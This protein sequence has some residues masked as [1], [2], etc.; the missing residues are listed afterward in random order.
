VQFSI[1]IS[2]HI[3]IFKLL[4]SRWKDR[5]CSVWVFKCI[6]IF[7]STVPRIC[8]ARVSS[9]KLIQIL[10][11]YFP[12]SRLYGNFQEKLS[13]CVPHFLGRPISVCLIECMTTFW[14]SVFIRSSVL[15]Q[16]LS[17]SLRMSPFS[18]CPTR[19]FPSVSI[20]T[21]H[22]IRSNFTPVTSIK[23][24]FINNLFCF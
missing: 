9:N 7:F 4:D 20:I 13:S 16:N 24:T 18:T 1:N 3:L 21:F 22:F 12:F 8:N 14:H 15:L 11:H 17:K 2:L 19:L 23:F 5:V 6:F 10:L